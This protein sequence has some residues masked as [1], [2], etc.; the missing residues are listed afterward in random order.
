MNLRW[1]QWDIGQTLIDWPDRVARIRRQAAGVARGDV[2]CE[3]EWIIVARVVA[4]PSCI[5]AGI[6][7]TIAATQ[8]RLVQ[9]LPLKPNPWPEV[10][11]AQIQ[12]LM[13]GC[14]HQRDALLLKQRD[15]RRRELNIL[16]AIVDQIH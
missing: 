13:I 10:L 12:E 1:Y 11:F 14:V 6:R 2:H 15:K 4:V 5:D 9:Y 16:N 3:R 8:Y 7:N